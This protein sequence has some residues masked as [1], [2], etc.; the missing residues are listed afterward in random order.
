MRKC[1][2]Q[3]KTKSDIIFL[4]QQITISHNAFN[5][6]KTILMGI[7]KYPLLHRLF[8]IYGNVN[9]IEAEV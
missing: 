2:L 6:Y 3:I 5:L 1:I 4:T 7:L 8:G 9:S